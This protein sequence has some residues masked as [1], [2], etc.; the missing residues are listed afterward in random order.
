MWK[1]KICDLSLIVFVFLIIKVPNC[2]LAARNG[3]ICGQIDVRNN[4]EELNRIKGCTVVYG[5]LQ[6]VLIENATSKDFESYSF[7]ELR[8]DYFFFTIIIL[9]FS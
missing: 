8:F 9:F 1:L 5:F 4:V 7:P 6:I 2:I 3:S